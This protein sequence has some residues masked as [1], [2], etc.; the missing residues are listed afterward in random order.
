MP[1]RKRASLDFVSGLEGEGGEES[2]IVLSGST[3]SSSSGE[4]DDADEDDAPGCGW[5]GGAEEE[6]MDQESAMSISKDVYRG[7]MCA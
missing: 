3:A 4:E 2:V 5:G 6:G 7:N 1:R